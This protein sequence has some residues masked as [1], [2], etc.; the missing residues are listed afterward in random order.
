MTGKKIGRPTEDPKPIR[1][2]VRMNEETLRILDAYCR[3]MGVT[4]MEGIRRGIQ[5]LKK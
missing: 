1:L 4:R 2:S 3:E 5:G